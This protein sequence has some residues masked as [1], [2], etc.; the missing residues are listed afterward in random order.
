MGTN[1]APILAK[2]YAVM[3][4]NELG[5]K[6]KN[7]PKQK[8]PVLLRRFIDD[9]FGIFYGTK[10]DIVYWIAQFNKLRESIKIDKWSIRNKVEY[11]DLEIYTGSRFF[12]CRKMDLKLHQKK[13][14][15]FL[16]LPYC[17]G[18]TAHKSKIKSLGNSKDTLD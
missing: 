4:E 2:I 13:E 11:M 8:W 15:K 6:C 10:E 9:G 7:D 12:K 18:H 3:L 16:Y 1:V 5:T 14:N 17:S